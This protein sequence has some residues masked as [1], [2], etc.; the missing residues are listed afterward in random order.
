MFWSFPLTD[1]DLKKFLDVNFSDNPENRLYSFHYAVQWYN[2]NFSN[3]DE[4]NVGCVLHGLLCY[5]DRNDL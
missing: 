4:R 2:P 3:E 1:L 5:T